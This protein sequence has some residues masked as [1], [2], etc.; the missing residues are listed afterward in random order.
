MFEKH[1]VLTSE[2]LRTIVGLKIV[3][4]TGFTED[5][6]PCKI[7]L[8]PPANVT[9]GLLCQYVKDAEME[10]CETEE[11]SGSRQA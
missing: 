11:D 10:P 4:L 9:H 5:G 3:E 1:R 6:V 8:H 2:E 7:V